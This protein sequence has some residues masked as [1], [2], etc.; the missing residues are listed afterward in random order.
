MDLFLPEAGTLESI[1]FMRHQEASK[2]PTRCYAPQ[3]LNGPTLKQLH[4]A[5]SRQLSS[6]LHSL[7]DGEVEYLYWFILLTI[8]LHAGLVS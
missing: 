2:E 5:R 8:S 7:K 4:H 1:A 6:M 3:L